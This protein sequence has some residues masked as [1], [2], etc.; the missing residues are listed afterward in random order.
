MGGEV[1][2]EV[3]PPQASGLSRRAWNRSAGGEAVEPG[4]VD[5]ADVDPVGD[6]RS[7]L[8]QEDVSFIRKKA[9]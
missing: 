4:G 8:S 6:V 5:E 3:A 9:S 1:R 7:V 2:K